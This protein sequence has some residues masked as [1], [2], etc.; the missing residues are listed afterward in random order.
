[1]PHGQDTDS[2]RPPSALDRHA[3]IQ[4][5]TVGYVWGARWRAN[6]QIWRAAGPMLEGILGS[7]VWVVANVAYGTYVRD[8][9]RGFKRVL[10]FYLGFPGTLCSAFVIP[11][12]KRITNSR[13]DELEE[14]REL[15]MEIRRDRA[16]RLSQSQGAE[17]GTDRSTDGSTDER[18][19]E[20][21]D[22]KA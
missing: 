21:G 10:A 14:E 1:M 11:R 12:S 9:E 7:L 17:E 22:E 8:G 13:G 2:A 16:R 6:T 4:W 5:W 3:S 19:D 20:A 18:T 15:L